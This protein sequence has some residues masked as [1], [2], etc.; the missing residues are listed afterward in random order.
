M[1]IKDKRAAKLALLFGTISVTLYILLFYFS[2]LTIEWARMT[3]QG[4]K[5]Y[6]I[7]PVIIAFVFSYFHGAFTSHF[8]DMLGFKPAAKKKGGK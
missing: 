7:L 8:W 5:E 4:Q 2:D 1:A 6:F 3:R